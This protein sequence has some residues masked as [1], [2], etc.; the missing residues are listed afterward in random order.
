[1]FTDHELQQAFEAVVT[2]RTYPAGTVIMRPGDVITQ[3]PIV[4]KG[5]LRILAQDP[6]GKERFL[7]HI[8]PGETCSLSLTCC[9][10]RK[11][12]AILA[13]V[14]EDAELQMVPARYA[15]EWMVYPEWRRYVGAAQAQRF[16][17]LLETI[18]TL[19]FRRMD[20]QLWNYL[21]KRAQAAGETNLKVTH[22][23][24]AQELGS[25]REVITRLL[26]Q[27]QRKGLVTL[28]RGAVQVHLANAG[29]RVPS[30]ERP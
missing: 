1:M 8:L 24:I 10:A 20:D 18:E 11:T 28:S 29:E 26:Q 3:I 6:D 2:R 14:E 27:L 19:A 15:D 13:V 4:A 16:G 5:S 9:E 12:S 21:V 30:Q 7:Y 23:D 17:E 25:P 22:Q